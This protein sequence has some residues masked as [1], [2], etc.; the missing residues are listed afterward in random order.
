MR[1]KIKRKQQVIKFD[2]KKQRIAGAMISLIGFN[3][4]REERKMWRGVNNIVEHHLKHKNRS[5]LSTFRR[6]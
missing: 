1:E 6:V 2:Q 4:N 5:D 3:I